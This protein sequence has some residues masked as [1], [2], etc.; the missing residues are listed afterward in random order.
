[1]FIENAII[2]VSESDTSKTVIT[3]KTLLT[4]PKISTMKYIQGKMAI[5][6]LDGSES[7]IGKFRVD[8]HI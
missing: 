5:V 2:L 1:L 6:G 7:L 4:I 8:I 3:G